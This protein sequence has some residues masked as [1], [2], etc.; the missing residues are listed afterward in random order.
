NTNGVPDECENLRG[1]MNGD[2]RID[3]SDIQEFVRCL[4]AGSV[5]GNCKRADMDSDNDVDLDDLVLFIQALMGLNGQD[6]LPLANC[7]VDLAIDSNNNGFLFTDIPNDDPI[8]ERRPGKYICVNDDDDNNNGIP[9]KDE[10]I[11]NAIAGEDDLV[12]ILMS[13]TCDPA[14]RKWKLTFP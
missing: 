6:C 14:G 3:G 11:G 13:T 4:L 5:A 7:V 1:D 10:P 12:P 8:E 2:G 9:D